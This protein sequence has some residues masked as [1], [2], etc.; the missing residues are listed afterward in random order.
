M[1]RHFYQKGN[2]D[3]QQVMKRC[4]TSLI[5]R[6]MQIKTT[7]RY[8]HTLVRMTAIRK[9]T[10]NKCWQGCGEKGTLVHFWWEWKLIQPLCKAEWRFLTC[11][12]I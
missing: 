9:N 3:D 7:I 10:D 6:E 8:H 11:L 5:V 2:A 12:N 1:N 4:P